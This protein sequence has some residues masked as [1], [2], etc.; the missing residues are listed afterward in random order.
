[1]VIKAS[2]KCIYQDD[3]QRYWLQT[4]VHGKR[5]PKLLGAGGLIRES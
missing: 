3:T 1:M 5:F 4:V 2:L